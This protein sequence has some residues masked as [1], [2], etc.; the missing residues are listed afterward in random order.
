EEVSL[1][2]MFDTERPTFVRDLAADV[3]IAYRRG[4]RIFQKLGQLLSW[5]NPTKKQLIQ[6]IV[7]RKSIAINSEKN[8]ETFEERTYRLRVDY[9]RM[10]YCYRV[11]K[12]PGK[13]TMIVNQS[14]Y[15]MDRT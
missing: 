2:V 7:R 6:D 9:R 4:K 3:R 11:K 8:V 10:I 14:Q 1:L 5:H 15:R 13:I 12:Y